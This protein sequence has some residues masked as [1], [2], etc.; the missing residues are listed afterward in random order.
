MSPRAIS[1]HFESLFDPGAK[2]DLIEDV[3]SLV[4]DFLRK[5][6]KSFLVRPPDA[7]RIRN[8][9][10]TLAANKAFEK[11]KRKDELTRYIE[12]YMIKALG[13]K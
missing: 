3:N 6:K 1:K 8:M 10:E 4:R 9:A 11:I 7:P 12:L 5:L 2:A 13:G